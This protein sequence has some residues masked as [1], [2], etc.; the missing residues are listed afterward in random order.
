MG[1]KCFGEMVGSGYSCT[2]TGG[3]EE[4]RKGGRGGGRG[5]EWGLG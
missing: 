4:G 1:D 2:Y 5:E 3:R